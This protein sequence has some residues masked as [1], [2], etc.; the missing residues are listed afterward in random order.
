MTFS[1]KQN[2]SRPHSERSLSVK[3]RNQ[4]RYSKH[5]KR[6]IEDV[7]HL[8]PGENL[9][10]E[11]W[12]HELPFAKEI[13][14]QARRLGANVLLS[15]EDDENY[16][17]LID[18]GAEKNLGV[19]G[20]HEWSLLENSDAYVF[21]PG[22]ADAQRQSSLDSKKRRAAQAYNQ[23]WYRRASRAGVRGVRI[24]TSYVTPSRARM[25][26]FDLR[27][28]YENTLDAID[29]DYRKIDEIGRKL[30]SH[31]KRG[32]KVRISAPSGTDLR[33][34][35]NGVTPHLYSGIMSR[36]IK[37]NIFSSVM[38]IPGNELDVVPYAN[39]VNGTV[40]FDR[41]VFSDSE[42]IEG[43]RWIFERG[44]LM[45]YSARKNLELFSGPYEQAKGDKDKAGVFAIGLN[46]KLRYGYN[47]D[48]H[49]A[50]SL[51]VG[52]GANYEGDKN[53][54]DYQFVATLSKATVTVGNKKILD[55]G[56]IVTN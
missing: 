23:E 24:R 47:Q 10:I 6:I 31:F 50:G 29:V 48:F 2:P 52:I 7:L 25:L 35:L 4:R 41:P 28:W 8:K 42:R 18:S 33:M 43:L 17:R 1:S 21:F 37:N 11:A 22:P 20:K 16:F 5:A 45:K 46:P 55:A 38:S 53:K 34:K 30:S 26:N 15:I 9:T 56:K 32:S 12:E 19:V 44:K 49:V 54:T 27:K 51:T 36:P 13:K 40:F 3:L 39:S 14:F